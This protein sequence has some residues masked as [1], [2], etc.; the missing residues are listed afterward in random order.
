MFSKD[1]S[2]C[3][4]LWLKAALN[5]PLEVSFRLGMAPFIAGD[6]LKACA[7]CAVYWRFKGAN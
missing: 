7:A 6:L 3:G 1:K 4:S 2:L 5:L